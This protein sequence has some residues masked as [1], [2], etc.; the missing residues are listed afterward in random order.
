MYICTEKYP[1]SNVAGGNFHAGVHALLACAK[2]CTDDSGCGGFDSDTNGGCYTME[3]EVECSAT[4][5]QSS[6]ADHYRK[7]GA[8]EPSK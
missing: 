1:S 5:R 3:S 4:P 6:I 8:C 2:L 7:L